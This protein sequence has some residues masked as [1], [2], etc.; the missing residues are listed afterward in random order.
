[1]F[2]TAPGEEAVL[3]GRERRVPSQLLD[4]V[5]RGSLRKRD[6][7]HGLT[8]VENAG[9][10]LLGVLHE[11]AVAGRGCLSVHAGAEKRIERCDDIPFRVGEA[12]PRIIRDQHDIQGLFVGVRQENRR[13]ARLLVT[14]GPDDDRVVVAE[15]IEKGQV[16]QQFTGLKIIPH[17]LRFITVCDG[18]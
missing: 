18:H 7:A 3:R 10:S 8:E 2:S 13:E 12:E 11:I 4:V 6:L 15:V 16:E 1:L 9:Q 17:M 5:K 14:F